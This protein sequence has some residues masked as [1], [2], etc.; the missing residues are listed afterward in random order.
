MV[1]LLVGLLL[2]T[3]ISAADGDKCFY[4]Y[5]ASNGLADNSAQT[6][7]CTHT[8]RLVITTMGQIN[9]Y[10]GQKFAKSNVSSHKPSSLSAKRSS[11]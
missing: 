11:T 7:H 5:N 6:I 1:I 2:T 3:V 9:F 4:V 8:G 10:D